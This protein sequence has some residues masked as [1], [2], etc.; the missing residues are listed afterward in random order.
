[1]GFVIVRGR[2]ITA[3]WSRPAEALWCKARSNRPA[4]SGAP[5]RSVALQ[6]DIKPVA[7]QGSPAGRS[8]LAAS[9]AMIAIDRQRDRPIGPPVSAINPRVAIQPFELDMGGLMGRRLQERPRVQT[10]SGCGSH[11]SARRQQSHDGVPVPRPARCAH[12]GPDREIDRELT[13]DDRLDAVAGQSCRRTPAPRTCCRVGQRQAPAGG[14]FRE[15]AEFWILI[16][17]FSSE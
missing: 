14:P 13:A 17:P 16:D 2:E 9:A 7:K 12:W 6:F 11:G 3:R 8:G 1:V 15:L 4:S 5:S 10:A